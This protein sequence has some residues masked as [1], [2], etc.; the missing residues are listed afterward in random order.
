MEKEKI[1]EFIERMTAAYP[2]A[3]C[4]LNFASAYGLLIS[5]VL[6]AQCTDKR[7]NEVTAKLFSRAESP[8][9]MLSLG[10]EK[11]AEIIRPCGLYQT[12][13]KHIIALSQILDSEY[14]GE[15]PGTKQELLRLP[16]V[17]VKTANVVLSNA[18]GI[19]AIA[20]DTHV[21]RVANRLGLAKAA[22]PEKTELQLNEA[23][24]IKSWSDMHHR[25]IWHGRQICHA[26]KPLCDAC[27][28]R[29]MCDYF[30]GEGRL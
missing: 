23:L 21:F 20:V 25:L 13:A 29:D 24:P 10:Y 30:K 16:G 12:K 6:S 5:T 22:T 17:G 26:R 9:E 18:F 15:V 19:P 14:G 1:P 7:V 27:P 2:D 8:S 28:V 4:G 11:L 3:K